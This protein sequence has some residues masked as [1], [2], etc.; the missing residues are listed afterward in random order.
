MRK[1]LKQTQ[2]STVKDILIE[3]IYIL[4]YL[5]IVYQTSFV[6]LFAVYFQYVYFM[7][8]PRHPASRTVNIKL[9]N[10]SLNHKFLLKNYNSI[11]SKIIVLD[12]EKTCNKGNDVFIRMP[13]CDITF[14]CSGLSVFTFFSYFELLELQSFE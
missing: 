2:F 14:N 9:R 1:A 7:K 4:F 13:H 12:N 5:V 6:I 3:I 8:T 11:V 10:N